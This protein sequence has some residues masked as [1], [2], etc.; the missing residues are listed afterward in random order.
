MT[1]QP[2]I[3]Y[4]DPCSKVVKHFGGGGHRNAGG[5]TIDSWADFEQALDTWGL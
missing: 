3:I 1:E 2:L 4:H 5:F